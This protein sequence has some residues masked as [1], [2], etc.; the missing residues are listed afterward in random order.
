MNARMELKRC[1]CT[2]ATRSGFPLAPASALP[3]SWLC[4]GSGS[5]SG[6]GSSPDPFGRRAATDTDPA[7]QGYGSETYAPLSMDRPSPI[8]HIP[9]HVQ[10]DDPIEGRAACHVAEAEWRVAG[11][12]EREGVEHDIYAESQVRDL[13]CRNAL[14]SDRV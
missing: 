5:G 13:P 6:S 10:L 9:Q 12:M 7:F 14:L 1:A 8:L 11:W 2:N 3:R 4:Y